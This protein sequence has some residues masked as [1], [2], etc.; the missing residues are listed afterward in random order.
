[1]R[2][3]NRSARIGRRMRDA[4]DNAYEARAQKRTQERQEAERVARAE[5]AA[6]FDALARAYEEPIEVEPWWKRWFLA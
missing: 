1:M 3:V 4:R 6:Q 5:R 2:V